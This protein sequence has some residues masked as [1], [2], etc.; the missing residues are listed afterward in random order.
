MRFDLSRSVLAGTT[1]AQRQQWLSDAQVAYAQ[2]MSGA[3]AVTVS[4]EGKSVS[5]AP[6]EAASLMSWIGLLQQS[7]GMGGRRRALRPYYR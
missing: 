5:Y 1:A 3:K 4:Y 6:T 7:L 2:L